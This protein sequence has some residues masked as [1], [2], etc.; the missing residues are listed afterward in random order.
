[1]QQAAT[2][3]LRWLGAAVLCVGAV[4]HWHAQGITSCAPLSAEQPLFTLGLIADVQ[5]ADVEDGYNYARTVRRAFRGALVQLGRAVDWWN[6]LDVSAVAQLGDLAD[7]R[8]AAMGQSE[9]AFERA[10]R[11]LRRLRAPVLN[12]VGNHELYNFQRDGLSRRLGG[13]KPFDSFVPAF[14]HRILVL[15]AYQEATLG[16]PEG[17][18]RRERAL[19]TLREHNPNDMAGGDWFRG[20]T[21]PG[22]RWVPYNGGL[23]A[24][25]LA[26]LRQEL[27]AARREGERVI[28]LSHVVARRRST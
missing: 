20:L 1:M 6:A 4:R 12:L 19:R 23:G 25:Q 15:G 8:N 11:E 9:V 14:G 10:M 27:R 13:A 18:P 22:R 26:W 28:V 17:D 3:W 2:R 7:G 5:F 16:W 21:G 24:E